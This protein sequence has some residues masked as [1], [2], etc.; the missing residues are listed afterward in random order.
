MWLV[1]SPPLAF[2]DEPEAACR[3]PTLGEVIGV[4]RENMKVW[5]SQG[6]LAKV[7]SVSLKL[8]VFLTDGRPPE[9]RVVTNDP[10][11]LFSLIGK[12]AFE[13]MLSFEPDD[14]D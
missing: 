14:L 8:T 9:L 10:I 13:M 4:L 1:G 12:P 6:T 3:Y 7:S 11:C 2:A 5:Q